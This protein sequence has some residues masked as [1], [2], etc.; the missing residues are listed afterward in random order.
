VPT[1][2]YVHALK[3]LGWEWTSFIHLED[4]EAF[5]RKWRESIA[6]GASFEGTA[7]VQR[8]DGVYRWMLHHKEPLRN[9]G[10]Y[11]TK[12]FGS[13]AAGLFDAV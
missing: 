1:I 13:A 8:A 10:G 7:R 12:W 9:S 11:I 2:P 3:L 6:T 5:V 4:V